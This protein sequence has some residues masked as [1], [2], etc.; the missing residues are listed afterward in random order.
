M[1]L[2]VLA[3]LS[4]GVAAG[5]VAFLFARS[6][7]GVDALASD[8]PPPEDSRMNPQSMKLPELLEW[9]TRN[10]PLDPIEAVEYWD[11]RLGWMRVRYPDHVFNEILD[12]RL[13][14]AVEQSRDLVKRQGL[15]L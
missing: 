3:G 15:A 13:R 2:F 14:L 12:A 11:E 10:A 4:I 6:R 1:E 7:P 8:G 9:W 5:V